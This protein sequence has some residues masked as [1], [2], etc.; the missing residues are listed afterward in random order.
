MGDM[1]QLMAGIVAVV[2]VMCFFYAITGQGKV[3]QNNYPKEMK[4]EA[5]KLLRK[6]FWITGP[7]ALVSGV[8]ELIGYAWG[9]YIGLAIV[10]L[11]VVYVVIFRRRFGEYLKK[12]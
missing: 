7:M 10:P 4:E 6:F 5:N 9:F 12:K 1:D 3:Y 11:I 2:G 8:L